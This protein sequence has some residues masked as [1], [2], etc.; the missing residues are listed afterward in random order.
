MIQQLKACPPRT[1]PR[2]RPRPRRLPPPRRLT[3]SPRYHHT[4]HYFFCN[5]NTRIGRWAPTWRGLDP[6]GY[7]SHMM[8]SLGRTPTPGGRASREPGCGERRPCHATLLLIGQAHRHSVS[9]SQVFKVRL[10]VNAN[11]LRRIRWVKNTYVLPLRR[12]RRL[13]PLAG[14]GQVG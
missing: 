5:A 11:T 1:R 9:L 3:S 4:C 2:P 8:T 12:L 14:L 13:R 7:P 6:D 10:K